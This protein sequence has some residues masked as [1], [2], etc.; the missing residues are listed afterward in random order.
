MSIGAKTIDFP[1]EG[2]AKQAEAFYRT[3]ASRYGDQ[4]WELQADYRA[5]LTSTHFME[6]L[7]HRGW[8][9]AVEHT[10]L[11]LGST[12]TVESR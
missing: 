1:P 12:V 2:I 5:A 10:E 9:E 3:R 7:E 11:H 4:I 8:V 6:G